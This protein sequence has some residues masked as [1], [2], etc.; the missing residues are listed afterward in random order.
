MGYEGISSEILQLS[1]S[2]YV[3]VSAH[4]V[5]SLRTWGGYFDLLVEI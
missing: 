1:R 2:P 3:N 4:L 5:P